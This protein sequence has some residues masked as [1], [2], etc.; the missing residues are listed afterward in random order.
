LTAEQQN[1]LER[2]K[3][4]EQFL[5]ARQKEH[6]AQQQIY[7]KQHIGPGMSGSGHGLMGGQLH[8]H[9]SAHSLHSQ[10]SFGSVTSPAAYQPSPTQGP[11]QGGPA[12][13]GFF[14]SAFRQTQGGQPSQQDILGSIREGEMPGLMERL[15]LNSRAPQGQQFP[16]G[17]GLPD[18]AQS[19]QIAAMLQDRARLQH[20][21]A[22]HDRRLSGQ[23]QEELEAH[24]RA[25]QERFQQFHELRQQ[26][27]QEEEDAEELEMREREEHKAHLRELEIAQAQMQAQV[28]QEEPEE[29]LTQQVQAASAAKQ[30]SAQ[31]SPWAKI[32]AVHAESIQHPGQS[33]SPMPAPIARRKDIVAD[34]LVAES[35]SNTQSPAVETPT[36]SLAPW[37]NQTVEV[38]K[39]LSLKEIQEAEA[40]RAAKQ[41]EL[42]AAQRRAA[43]ERELAAAQAAQSIPPAP[44]LPTGATW[45]SQSPAAATGAGPTAWGAKTSSKPSSKTLQ[46]IQKEEEAKKQRAA[47]AAA[48][49]VAV[50]AGPAPVLGGKRYAD[51]AG[52]SASPAS[53]AAPA[54]GWT[55]IGA[56]GKVKAAAPS[57]TATAAPV[58][59]VSGVVPTVGKP[60][61]VSRSTT[62]GNAQLQ[63]LTKADALG[64]FKKWAG[65]E[66]Q[67]GGL[68]SS[69]NRKSCLSPRLQS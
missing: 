18:E 34:N 47:V 56:G 35:R 44:G 13:P 21:Q 30:A 67:R 49:N 15:A 52:K 41:E 55:T 3:Q 51:L 10:P 26:Q 25:T 19:Q 14:D 28:Q 23:S 59:S 33:A 8:H 64:E 9:S 32:D 63:K 38:P 57:P 6:L 22:E 29:T 66:L 17:Q 11:L 69:I 1:A 12:V 68:H 58:R 42:A 20:E 7:M 24:E 46:Q 5:M 31:Q 4:E 36:T 48:A 37:A 60:S 62:M 16:L 43:Y 39:T 45:A 61:P 54:G 27:Q 65:S 50:V 2:R 40:K 53:A